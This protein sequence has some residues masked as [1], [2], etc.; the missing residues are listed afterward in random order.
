MLGC[1][2]VNAN[3]QVLHLIFELVKAITF[4]FSF[5]PT[6]ANYFKKTFVTCSCE[7]AS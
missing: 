4:D 3:D 1:R 7:K 6:K 2:L 5:Q